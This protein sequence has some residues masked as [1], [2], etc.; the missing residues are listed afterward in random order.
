MSMWRAMIA[1]FMVMG[2]LLSPAWGQPPAAGYIL[3]EHHIIWG[4]EIW[5]IGETLE[6]AKDDAHARGAGLDHDGEELDDWIETL[7]VRR[8]TADLMAAARQDRWTPSRRL[9]GGVWGTPAEYEANP[10]TRG[11]SS[12]RA[13]LPRDLMTWEERATFRAQMLRATPEE[14]TA[15]WRQKFALLQ[16]RATAHGVSLAAPEMRPDGTLYPHEIRGNGPAQL[17]GGL[18]APRLFAPTASASRPPRASSRG[19]GPRRLGMQC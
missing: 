3:T 11:R 14:R 9:R 7:S 17:R 5:G 16:Q 6:Q 15:L 13:V 18:R 10:S 8:A 1:A 2:L 4:D 19:T 12:S